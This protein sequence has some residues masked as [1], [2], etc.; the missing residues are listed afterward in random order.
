[1]SRNRGRDDQA[2]AQGQLEGQAQGQLEAQAQGQLE[3]QAQGQGQGQSQDQSQ[4][5]GQN[6]YQSAFQGVGQAAFALN[7][8]KNENENENENKNENT[9]DNKVENK[10][11]SSVDNDVENKVEN[12]VENNVDVNVDVK[13]DLEL[14]GKLTTP[15]D[16]DVI[17]I[18]E[19]ACINDSIVMPDVV[20]QHLD[21]GNMFN[22]DQ[23]N[24]LADQDVSFAAL[25]YGSKSSELGGLG[26]LGAD[27]NDGSS[28]SMWAKAEGGEA[29]ANDI[30]A[31]V[32]DDGS[33]ESVGTTTAD[34]IVNQEAFTQ[35]IVLGS[36]IQFNQ[37]DLTV[38]GH[39]LNMDDSL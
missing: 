2:Q 39:D 36:N 21:N 33:I 24:N 4:S 28:F 35:N 31:K 15:D 23:V 38:A 30:E 34:A 16:D 25:S 20:T 27:D 13:V 14:D 8:N 6:T 37:I 5:Q 32:G 12:N 22:I 10:V 3:L 29:K 9:V 1:M 11:E 7:D 18:E 17:D 26:A 19:I